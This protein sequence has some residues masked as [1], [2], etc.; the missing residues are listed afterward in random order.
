MDYFN[1]LT[2]NIFLFYVIG[3]SKKE[4]PKNR[5]AQIH[6]ENDLVESTKFCL[7]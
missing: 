5:K 4:G 7:I 6:F 2:W 1:L 3:P